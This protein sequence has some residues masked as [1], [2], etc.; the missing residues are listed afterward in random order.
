MVKGLALAGGLAVLVLAAVAAVVFVLSPS[1]HAPDPAASVAANQA[2]PPAVFPLR[3]SV[4]LERPWDSARS[5]DVPFSCTGDDSYESLRQG[6]Q[7]VV[8]DS[9]GKTVGLSQLG[10]GQREERGCVFPFEVTNI[11]A[12]QAFYGV[13]VPLSGRRQYTASQ[14]ASHFELVIKV[15]S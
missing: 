5:G 7:V 10:A 1:T 13:E 15:P 4:I 9:S 12:G 8:T 14:V 11:P 6:G 3:G 2:P